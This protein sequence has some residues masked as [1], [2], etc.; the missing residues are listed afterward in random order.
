[1]SFVLTLAKCRSFAIPDAHNRC[2]FRRLRLDLQLLWMF[3]GCEEPDAEDHEAGKWKS[4][5]ED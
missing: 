1:M 2:F 5:L 3:T 4:G